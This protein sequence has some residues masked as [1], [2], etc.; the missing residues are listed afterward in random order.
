[1]THPRSSAAVAL[2]SLGWVRAPTGSQHNLLLA[3]GRKKKAIPWHALNL[4]G[5][6]VGASACVRWTSARRESGASGIP[7]AVNYCRGAQCVTLK[8]MMTRT[9]R[10]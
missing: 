1:M 5:G 3:D 8:S 6:A 9:L 7:Q 2:R 10:E 4:C